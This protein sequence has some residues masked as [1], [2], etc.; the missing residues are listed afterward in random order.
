M[1]ELM[2]SVVERSLQFKNI[3]SPSETYVLYCRYRVECVSG[4]NSIIPIIASS[5]S[6]LSLSSQALSSN[7][8][9]P[10]ESHRSAHAQTRF[11]VFHHELLWLALI[12]PSD[13]IGNGLC[14]NRYSLMLL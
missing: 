5:H 9:Q 2:S 7:N 1:I 11:F 13:I 3:I 14:S 6:H 8:Y 12:C 4:I 10:S